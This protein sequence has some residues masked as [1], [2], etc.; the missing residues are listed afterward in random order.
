MSILA[1]NDILIFNETKELRNF[2]GEFKK[3]RNIS[4]TSAPSYNLL[5]NGKNEKYFVLIDK[6]YLN[7][8][9]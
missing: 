1:K 4:R 6:Y 3:E 7:K 2:I 9:L 5:M 8:K